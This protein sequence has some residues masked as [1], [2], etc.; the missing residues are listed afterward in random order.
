MKLD[1]IDVELVLDEVAEDAE[2]VMYHDS[3]IALLLN[4]E[5]VRGTFDA[6][7]FA[8]PRSKNANWYLMTC[9]CGI[10]GCAGYHYGINVKRRL[11]TVEWH[12]HETDKVTFAKRFY[13][14]NKYE[15]E[16]AQDKCL[17]LLYA[18]V[19]ERER[20]NVTDKQLGYNGVIPWLTTERLGQAIDHYQKYIAK[21][22][23]SWAL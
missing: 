13:S 1:T 5:R 15:Y 3:W 16:V 10:A 17:N 21:N 20:N 6:F 4:G 11:R 22:N 18:I 12:D 23:K 14:F 8:V 9:S 19:N 2:E 7:E